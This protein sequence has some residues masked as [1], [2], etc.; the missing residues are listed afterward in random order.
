MNKSNLDTLKDNEQSLD[1][2]NIS[3]IKEIRDI[4]NFGYIFKNSYS[5]IDQ[6]SNLKE[7][8]NSVN[9]QDKF[10]TKKPLVIKGKPNPN[11]FIV[12]EEYNSS[13]DNIP[14]LINN[15]RKRGKKSLKKIN[16]FQKCHDNNRTDNLLRKIQVHYMSFIV[17]F[18]NIILKNLNYREKFLKLDYQFK[19]NVN[20][21]FVEALKKKTIREIIC[22]NI[23]NKYKHNPENTNSLI[24]EKVKGEKVIY[25]ILEE[26]Y[27]NLFRKF[28]YK[29]NKTINLNEYGLNKL[30]FLSNKVKMF[31]DLLRDVKSNEV[32]QKKISESAKRNYL[33]RP[34][35][36]IN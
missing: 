31:K 2:S 16:K 20:K 13:Q 10:T 7:N 33:P 34:M 12:K 30:I 26:N 4:S 25:N 9:I 23:S 36:I 18:L 15:K 6:K 1:T 3:E 35:F 5:N 21:D 11:K 17:S 32:H 14:V 8:E 29:S 27:L 19:R 22:N 28:Y 24:Y